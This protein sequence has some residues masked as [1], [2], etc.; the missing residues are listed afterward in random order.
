MKVYLSSDIGRQFGL[1]GLVSLFSMLLLTFLFFTAFTDIYYQLK[2]EESQ[3]LTTAGLAMT[4]GF[5]ELSSKGELSE[6]DAKAIALQALSSS[7]HI[8]EGYYWV[9]D[10]SGNMVM[11]PVKPELMQIDLS[12]VQD[13]NGLYL[14][15]EF[16]IA[17]HAGGGWVDYMWPKPGGDDT[18]YPKV[19]YVAYFEPWDWV[20]GTGIYLDEVAEQ[21][22]QLA[23]QAAKLILAAV[24]LMV[25]ISVLFAKRSTTVIKDMAIKDPLTGLFSRRYLNESE[26]SFISRDKRNEDNHLYVIFLDLDHFKF[27]NDNFGHHFGDDVLE[28]VGKVL[29]ENTRPQDLAVR[30]GGE[31]FVILMLAESIEPVLQLTERIRML[32]NK[33]QFAHDINLTISAGVAQRGF[34]ESFPSVLNR[35]DH[36]LYTAKAE[37]RDRVVFE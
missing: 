23:I 24:L 2:K 34:E 8:H 3:D 36:N 33:L 19:S 22:N 4:K 10:S 20:I 15:N 6:E 37:G 35:A 14:F 25:L 29:H 17:A 16:V 5:Y 7:R 28:A 26:D 31:E 1:M 32:V 30:Y 21:K 27:I 18:A 11:H 9:N 12:T 13:V